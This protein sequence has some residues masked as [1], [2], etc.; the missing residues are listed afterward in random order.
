[1]V[2]TATPKHGGVDLGLG[3]AR[4]LEDIE[5]T[6][7]TQSQNHHAFT[8]MASMVAIVVHHVRIKHLVVEAN[9]SVPVPRQEGNV[10]DP[11][12]QGFHEEIPP[13]ARRRLACVLRAGD[14]FCCRTHGGTMASLQS[15]T[16]VSLHGLTT[17]SW[18]G[19]VSILYRDYNARERYGTSGSMETQYTINRDKLNCADTGSSTLNRGHIHQRLIRRCNAREGRPRCFGGTQRGSGT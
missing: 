5:R 7:P 12:S 1:M 19:G 8:D 4:H 6:L 14:R 3:I 2:E 16:V 18:H 17:L 11:V 15:A 10:V 9:A 13:Y